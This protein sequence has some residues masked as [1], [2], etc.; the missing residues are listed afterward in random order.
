MKIIL[1]KVAEYTDG[2]NADIVVEAAGT[3]QTAATVF[4]YAKKGGGV[5][6][7]GIPYADVAMERF[8]FE[9]VLRSELTVWGSWSCVS[10][11]FPGK[12]LEEGPAMFELL[13]ERKELIGKVIMYPEKVYSI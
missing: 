5:V 2:M 9:K 1:T 6:F 11:P 12:E 3:P 13:M 8:Y 10:A 4:G 7:L